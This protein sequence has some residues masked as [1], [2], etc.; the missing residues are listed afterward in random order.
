MKDIKLQSQPEM[1][2]RKNKE[3]QGKE[4]RAVKKMGRWILDNVS[5]TMS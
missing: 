5:C 2:D 3:K 1:Y 4:V